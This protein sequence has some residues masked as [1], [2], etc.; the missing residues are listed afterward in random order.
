[1][2]T[3]K[4]R[5][6]FDNAMSHYRFVNAKASSVNT[7]E[8]SL[9]V[10]YNMVDLRMVPIKIEIIHV[11]GVFVEQISLHKEKKYPKIL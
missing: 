9:R 8:L 7:A 6:R 4:L 5:L 3:L 2:K 11:N 1:M 10:A